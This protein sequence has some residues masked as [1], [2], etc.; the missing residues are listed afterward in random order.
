[1]DNGTTA[2]R[3]SMYLLWIAA[4]VGSVLGRVLAVNAVDMIRLEHYLKKRLESSLA[5]ARQRGDEQAVRRYEAELARGTWRKQ[6]P[7]L[8]ANDRSRWCTV[9]ALVE[10]GTYKIDAIVSQ[11]NWDTIDMVKH[12]GAGRPAPGP[13]EGHLYSSK[14]P[15]YATLM[16]A[17]Y[18]L[19]HKLTGWTLGTHPYAIGRMLLVMFNVLPLAAYWLVLARLVDRYAATDGGR[20]LVMAAATFGTFLTTFAVVINNHLPAAI[21]ALLALYAAMR[22]WCDG[23][24][25]WPYFACCGLFG[26]L[27]VTFELPAAALAC[28]LAAMLLY[29][30]PRHTLAAAAPA[31]VAVAAAFFGTNYAAHGRW[32]PPYAHR[33][34]QDN[35]Y[36]Y[37]YRLPG[38]TRVRQSYWSDRHS[39]SPIDQGEPSPAVY[40]V[41]V[42]V[43]HHGIFSLTPLWL[44]TI[45]GLVLWCRQPGGTRAIGCLIAIVSLVVIAFYLARPVDD[46]NYGGMTSGFRWTFWLIPLWLVG[47]IPIA[48]R[49]SGRPWLQIA[50]AL[51]LCLSALSAAYPT[52]NPWTH[53]WILQFLLEED[54]VSLGLQDAA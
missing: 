26:A 18:W 35:W 15:L 33:S 17:P 31:A 22:I 2:L 42:L 38:E 32:S 14:P 12:D 3:R 43:G 39:R 45:P 36:D 24:R 13:D 40:A 23:E 10:H 54:L 21:C 52:W 1:M 6:R 49:A 47:L 50:C 8:S 9:R 44:L 25:R 29:K 5:E 30:S 41:H 34:P 11:P 48:D 20:C 53:P 7:F 46:R 19:I 28:L 27:T 51:L 37:Q 4:A 16:A